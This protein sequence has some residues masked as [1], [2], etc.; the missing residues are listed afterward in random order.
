MPRCIYTGRTIEVAQTLDVVELR[1]DSGRWSA[2][3]RGTVV[4][5]LDDALL[6]E[7]AD[8]HGHTNDLIVLP[9]DAVAPADARERATA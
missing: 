3:T 2:G 1:V 6:V 4:E 9:R 7:V 8:E 5:V